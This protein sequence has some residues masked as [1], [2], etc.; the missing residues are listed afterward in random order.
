MTKQDYEDY[1]EASALGDS[2][3]THLIAE[4]I[5]NERNFYGKEYKS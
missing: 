3:T 5:E 1:F 2:D 4:Q